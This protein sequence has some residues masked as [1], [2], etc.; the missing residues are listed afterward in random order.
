MSALNYNWSFGNGFNS[1]LTNPKHL[2]QSPTNYTVNLTASTVEG[3]SNQKSYVVTIYNMPTANFN[4]SDVCLNQLMNFTSTSSIAI[5]SLSYSWNFGD[6]ATSS[7]QNPVHLYT[8]DQSYPVTLIV[9]SNFNCKDTMIKTVTVN[10]L[11]KVKFGVSPVCDGITSQFSDSSTINSG[12]ISNYNW[13][14]SDGS[15]STAQNPFH[16][17]L[18]VGNYNVTL[19]AISNFGCVNDTTQ[20]VTVNPLPV[21]NFQIADACLGVNVNFTNGSTVLFGSLSYA[22]DLGDGGA[23]T[24]TNPVNNYSVAGFYPVKLIATSTAGC[25]DS[26][27][28]YAEVFTL[29]IVNAGID[30]SVSQGFEVQL[31]GFNPNA[32]SYNWTPDAE[33]NNGFVYNPIAT[34]LETTDYMLQVTDANGCVGSDIVKVKV[35]KDYRLFIH[36]VITPDGNGQNDTWHITNIETFESAD[37][38]V[39]DRW[40]KEVLFVKGYNSDWEGVSGTDQL[41]DGTYYYMIEFSDSD[42]VYKGSIT[43]LRNK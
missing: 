37:V 15:S 41:P 27:I 5:G 10:P 31:N 42:K 19:S 36:N 3:C 21:A 30:T 14:F 4:Y 39:Y 16:L 12:T 20:L 9:N 1:S 35:N 33:L 40:G 22:W 6:A 17:F 23:S 2:Y 11:P 29:P 13:D 24:A 26:I 43:I 7:V 18:N 28:K 32:L 25:K 34:P 8:A 38:Y